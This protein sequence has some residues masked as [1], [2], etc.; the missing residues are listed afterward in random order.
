MRFFHIA[1]SKSTCTTFQEVEITFLA[2][3]S[4]S[5][6]NGLFCWFAFK[7]K[8]SGKVVSWTI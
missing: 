6:K 5:L 2:P 3:Y 1:K 7:A 4:S 8:K